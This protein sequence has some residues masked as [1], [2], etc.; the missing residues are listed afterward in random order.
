LRFLQ[1]SRKEAIL[2]HQAHFHHLSL[3]SL[4]AIHKV[5]VDSPWLWLAAGWS[6]F[7]KAPVISLVYGFFISLSMQVVFYLLQRDELFPQAIA[8]MAGFV[9]IGPLFA[10]GLYE[11]SRRLEQ[12]LPV[13]LSATWHGWRRNSVSLLGIGA[14]MV[15]LLLSWFMLSLVTAVNLAGLT[16]EFGSRGDALADWQSFVLSLRWPIAL[17][18]G[19]IGF[20]AVSVAFVLSVVSVPMLTDREDMDVITAIVASAHTVRKNPAAMILWACLIA[21]FTG[22]A[23]APLFLGLIIA[24]PLLAY[25]SWHAYRD[26]IE[27]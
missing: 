10:V 18:F 14:V 17:S 25:A 27:H 4:P 5:S 1:G 9:F 23:V 21:L 24:F 20:L 3:A 7:T 13:T 15:L 26:L 2:A 12:R 16:G 6:D 8:L 11:I 19:L 22:V